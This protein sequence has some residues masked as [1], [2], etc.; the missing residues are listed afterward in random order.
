MVDS[1]KSTPT[2]NIMSKGHSGSLSNATDAKW[3]ACEYATLTYWFLIVKNNAN[4]LP[5]CVQ[6]S[7]VIKI[8]ADEGKLEIAVLVLDAGTLSAGARLV[9][10]L[11]LFCLSLAWLHTNKSAEKVKYKIKGAMR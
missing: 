6:E 1:R 5:I 10:L 7:K 9:E 2:Q 3:R 4:R 11:N 8:D